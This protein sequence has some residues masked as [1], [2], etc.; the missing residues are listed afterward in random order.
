MIDYFYYDD[1]E[2][3]PDYE[4]G[5]NPYLDDEFIEIIEGE[6]IEDV[7]YDLE[8]NESFYESNNWTR[9]Q[10]WDPLILVALFMALVVVFNLIRDRGN[11]R[12]DTMETEI[13]VTS[14]SELETS[15]PAEFWDYEAFD[16]PY[17]N[18]T[19]TQGP[20]GFTYGHMAIDI[21]AGKG[22]AILSPINGQVTDKSID[23]LGNT[24]LELENDH[25]KVTFLHGIYSIEIGEAVR[26]GQKIGKESNQGNTYDMAGRSCRG[27]NCGYHTH[28]NVFDKRLGSNV[29]PLNLIEDK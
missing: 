17:Q 29:N 26:I 18:F 22:S 3:F 19:L 13:E 10:A 24:V 25:Y 12:S 2:F 15:P 5:G 27:R 23:W 11:A 9:G 8:L 20:H 4:H 14:R 7:E 1:E 21:T 28:L 16:S 6:F